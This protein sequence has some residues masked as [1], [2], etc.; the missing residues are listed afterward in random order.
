MVISLLGR[1]KS[2]SH[3]A[4]RSIRKPPESIHC[5]KAPFHTVEIYL[6][7]LQVEVLQ[8]WWPLHNDKST[9]I[10]NRPT[11]PKEYTRD[12]FQLFH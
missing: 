10:D 7:R 11:T 3:V 8:I 6:R 1:A 2:T 5:Q 9:A 12:R 4:P